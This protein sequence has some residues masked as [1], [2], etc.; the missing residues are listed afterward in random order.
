MTYRLQSM[1]S[2]WLS[3][4]V[5][6]C[7]GVVAG[8]FWLWIAIA[9]PAGSRGGGPVWFGVVWLAWLLWALKRYV[10]M[11]HTIEII[12]DGFI[13]FIGAFHTTTLAPSAVV[14]V[15]AFAGQFVYLHHSNGKILM[16][17]QFTGF[18]EFLMHL[19]QANSQVAMHGV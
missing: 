4:V 8:V 7:L 6:P 2:Y 13:K 17:A 11:P 12:D 15:K 1:A 14:S 16:L 5:M 3:A 19:K 9:Q 10:T 18:H